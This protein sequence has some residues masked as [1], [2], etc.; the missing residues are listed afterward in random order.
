MGVTVVSA[1]ELNEVVGAGGVLSMLDKKLLKYASQRLTPIEMADRLD[2]IISPPQAAQ[3]VREILRSWD[4]LSITDQKALVMMDL[5]EL[6]E[7]LLNRVRGEG[8]IVEDGDGGRIYSYGDPRW[9]AAL[10]KV[11]TQ[12]EK[13]IVNTQADLDAERGGIRRAHAMV[14]VRAVEMAF[15]RLSRQL[16]EE[17]P[18]VPESRMRHAIEDAVPLAIASIDAAV[19]EEDRDEE[20]RGNGVGF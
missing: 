19:S 13:M 15:D 10:T 14:F 17:F 6:K 4:W 18:Q 12:M 2:N 20:T 16:R 8:G 5:V 1:E 11:L 7:I 3:R 9:A